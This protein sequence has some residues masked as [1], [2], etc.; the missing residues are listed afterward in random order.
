M[1]VSAFWCLPPII[2][3]F[4]GCHWRESAAD[5]CLFGLTRNQYEPIKMIYWRRHR[6]YASKCCHVASTGFA[7]FIGRFQ[8]YFTTDCNS[9]HWRRCHALPMPSIECASFSKPTL[10]AWSFPLEKASNWDPT[11]VTV[12]TNYGSLVV[13]F[14][15]LF[16]HHYLNRCSFCS[17]S[18]G[19]QPRAFA[20]L[21]RSPARQ[22]TLCFLSLSLSLPLSVSLSLSI[23]SMLPHTPYRPQFRLISFTT[24]PQATWTLPHPSEVEPA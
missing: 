11:V 9:L 13:L 20:S 17:C 22:Y 16:L 5:E 7:P 3:L 8:G 1:T 21:S 15:S 23:R 18:S 6:L 12:P 2:E 4:V 10:L 19:S 24:P 14:I